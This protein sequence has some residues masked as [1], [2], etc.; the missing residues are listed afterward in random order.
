MFLYIYVYMLK[1]KQ[2]F[3][4]LYE[5]KINEHFADYKSVPTGRE[6]VDWFINGNK[7]AIFSAIRSDWPELKE[8]IEKNNYP[9]RM[10]KFGKAGEYLVATKTMGDDGE[11]ELDTVEQTTRNYDD[12]FVK[13]TMPQDEQDEYHRT[14]GKFLGYSDEDIEKFIERVKTKTLPPQK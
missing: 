2:F 1:Y 3:T 5:N 4:H 10:I 9:H 8:F 7:R 12:I 6:E 11:K 14:L 13:K